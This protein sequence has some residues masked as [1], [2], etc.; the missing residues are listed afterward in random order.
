MP[1]PI[2]G[3]EYFGLSFK[4]YKGTELYKSPLKLDKP[5]FELA[6]SN[7]TTSVVICFR[8]WLRDLML[9]GVDIQWGMKCIGYEESDDEVWA[10]FQDG[11]SVKGDILIGSDGIHSPSICFEFLKKYFRTIFFFNNFLIYS[12]KTKIT[13][14]ASLRL[15]NYASN[16]GNSFK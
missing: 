5:L 13:T 7:V 9:E 10:I 1:M 8:D 15:W 4:N 3:K 2:Q 12:S 11:T 16:F 14:F 6:K